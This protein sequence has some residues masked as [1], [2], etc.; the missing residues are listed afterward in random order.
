MPFDVAVDNNGHAVNTSLQLG[1]QCAKSFSY[2]PRM[3]KSGHSV[4]DVKDVALILSCLGRVLQCAISLNLRRSQL[5][6]RLVQIVF[7]VT[8]YGVDVPGS[9][10][11]SGNGPFYI[12]RN[13][14]GRL[15]SADRR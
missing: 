8:M 13:K 3:R 7:G 4:D 2:S 14:T 1:P 15:F 5:V 12:A 9:S 11:E 6:N 10:F